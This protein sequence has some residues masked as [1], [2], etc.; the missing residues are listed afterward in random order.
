ITGIGDSI[1]F[2]KNSQ[3]EAVTVVADGI[4]KASGKAIKPELVTASFKNIDFTLDPVPSSLLKGA[5]NAQAIGLLKPVDN[6]KGI[7]DLKALDRVLKQ[8]G[9]TEVSVP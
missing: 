8:R 1:D 7:Y 3:S 4:Q 9:E 6:L 5:E 2:I